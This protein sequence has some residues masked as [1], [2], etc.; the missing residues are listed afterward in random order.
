MNKVISWKGWKT[1]KTFLQINSKNIFVFIK[2]IFQNELF[3]SSTLPSRPTDNLIHYF[4][5]CLKLESSTCS[6]L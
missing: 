6:K 3:S 1:W 5:E 4:L 2:I